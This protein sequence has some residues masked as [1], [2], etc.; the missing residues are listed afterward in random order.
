MKLG[1]GGEAF[2]VF[3]TFEDI[4]EDLQTSPLISPASSPPNVS[5]Q[6]LSS[7][8]PLQEPDFLDIGTNAT[9]QPLEAGQQISD[10]GMLAPVTLCLVFKL[11]VAKVI[12]HRSPHHR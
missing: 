3:E 11:T 6:D 8:I 4:P 7:S 10:P 5:A 12:L 2:F 1:E 9:K